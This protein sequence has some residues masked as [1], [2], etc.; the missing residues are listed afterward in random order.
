[1][2]SLDKTTLKSVCLLEIKDTKIYLNLIYI[3]LD[4]TKTNISM[5]TGFGDS[6]SKSPSLSDLEAVAKGVL[7]PTVI[8]SATADKC[9]KEAQTRALSHCSSQAVM[10]L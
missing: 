2:A 9:D 3:A 7:F 1:M 4:G 5:P 8:P 10:L 6:S